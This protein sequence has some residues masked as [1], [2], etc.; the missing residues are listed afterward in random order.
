MRRETHSHQN[1][2][3]EKCRSCQI[4]VG[5]TSKNSVFESSLGK[6][7]ASSDPQACE[8]CM[9]G[10]TENIDIHRL[11]ASCSLVEH[12]IVYDKECPCSE[13]TKGAD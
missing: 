3:D 8:K 4:W 7:K 11:L 6:H 1:E 13:P 5:D 2:H 9:G 12:R 10:A